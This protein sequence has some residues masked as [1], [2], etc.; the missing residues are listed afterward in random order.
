MRDDMAR[1]RDV[2]EAID[3]IERHAS[4]GRMAF[5][6]NE[7]MQVWVVHH[8][9]IIGEACRAISA[10]FKELHPEIPWVQVVGMRNILVH[11]YF[12]ID[13]PLLWQVVEHDL[14]TLKTN[15]I[16]LLGNTRTGEG[17]GT[18]LGAGE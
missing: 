2:L 7:L 18:D 6:E 17:F 10:G 12:G 1:L 4:G 5:E 9:Q 14:P 15:V 13:A 8:L 16:A 3:N 11:H